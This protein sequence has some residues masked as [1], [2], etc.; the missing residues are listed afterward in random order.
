MANPEAP[1]LERSSHL[2]RSLEAMGNELGRGLVP[3]WIYNDEEL[4]RAELER[5]FARNWIFMAHETEIPQPGDFVRRTIGGDRFIVVRGE[6]NR[7]RVLFDSCR[8][9][10]AS[11]CQGDKGNVE[12]FVC[13]YHGWTYSNTGAID[14]IPNRKSAFKA[15]EEEEWGLIPA[16]RVEFYRGLVFASLDEGVCPLLDHIGDYQ[17]YLDL[18]LGLSAGGMEV[19]GEPHHWFLD[20]DWKSGSENFSGDSYHTQSLHRSVLKLG[21]TPRAAAG[22][23]GGKNDI[24]VTECDGHATSIRRKDPG[25]TYF[26]GYPEEVYRHFDMEGFSDAQ[27]DLASESVVHTGTLFPNLSLIHIPLTDDPDKREFPFFSLRQWNPVAPGKT[28][29]ISWILAPKEATAE[30]KERSYKVATSTFS[31]SGNFEQDDSIAWAGTA[32]SAG[33]RFARKTGMTLNYQ[34]GMEHMSEA[35]VLDDWE[36]PGIVYDTNLEE[37]VQRTFFNHWYREMLQGVNAQ[38]PV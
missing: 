36:G 14:A 19:I 28:E 12:I 8:H 15:L 33:G 35:R 34:M 10:G 9:R 18:H 17:W 20:V 13:P 11:V 6:D 32:R 1:S 21:L 29:V 2:D 3:L 31:V 38:S 30:H 37:G 7:I 22:A 16:P 24:H 23:S 5:I 25:K 4:Y 26:W 27:R